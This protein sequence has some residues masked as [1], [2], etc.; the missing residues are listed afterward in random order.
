LGHVAV[1]DGCLE[2]SAVCQAAHQVAGD[3]LPGCLTGGNLGLG[4]CASLGDFFIG[5]QSD[6]AARVQIDADAI[7][8]ADPAETAAACAFG[9]GGKKGRPVGSGRMP[10]VAT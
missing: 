1:L 7:A 3:L 9:R 8:A 4:A 2:T 5:D 10:A 6:A